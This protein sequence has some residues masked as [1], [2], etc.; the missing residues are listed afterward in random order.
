MEQKQR[1]S[2]KGAER[3]AFLGQ[4]RRDDDRAINAREGEKQGYVGRHMSCGGGR[5]DGLIAPSRVTNGLVLR[6]WGVRALRS[7]SC[8][9]CMVIGRELTHVP[10]QREKSQEHCE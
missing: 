5:D 1:G 10:E 3:L 8:G 2:S 4:P 6:L 7:R 9:E